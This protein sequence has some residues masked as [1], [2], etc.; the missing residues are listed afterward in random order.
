MPYKEPIPPLQET[1]FSID[2]QL[3]MGNAGPLRVPRGS[4][5]P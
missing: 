5:R 3:W 1:T 4:M 2:T